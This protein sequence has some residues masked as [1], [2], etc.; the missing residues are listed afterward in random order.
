MTTR[1]L[2]A[3]AAGV[4]TLTLCALLLHLVP[5][6]VARLALLGAALGAVVDSDL[7][8]RR[9][10]NRI[11]VP[12]AAACAALSAAAGIALFALAEGLVLVAALLGLSLIR[13]EA[14]GMGDVKLAL[15]LVLG[16]DGRSSFALLVAFALA[17]GFGLLLIV[18]RGRAA[19]SRRLP[20]A[21]FFAAGTLLALLA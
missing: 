15:L 13:P 3:V 8:E 1:R 18:R 11:V 14:L 6:A 10:P 20:L 4:M 5:L 7:T 17:A 19:G 9:I 21:P 16:L 2:L 12:T